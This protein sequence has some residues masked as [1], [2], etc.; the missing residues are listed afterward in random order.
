M[1]AAAVRANVLQCW[2]ARKTGACF[3]CASLLHR[4]TECTSDSLPVEI[5]AIWPRA[6]SDS[7]PE[8]SYESPRGP[9]LELED[10]TSS[11]ALPSLLVSVPSVTGSFFAAQL[12]PP[13]RLSFS[14]IPWRFAPMALPAGPTFGGVAARVDADASVLAHLDRAG[15]LPLT[16][17]DMEDE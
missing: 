1:T 12:R 6:A 14:P 13:A 4:A 15:S 3:V 16:W 8:D 7:D 17:F 11:P 10:V 9:W 2:E 5:L